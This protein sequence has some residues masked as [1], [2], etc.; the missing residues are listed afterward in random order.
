MNI[1]YI[2]THDAGVYLEPYGRHIP[3][4]NLMKFTGEGT[5]AHNFFN[6]FPTCSPSRSALLTGMMP[7]S[8][9]MSG[10]AHRGWRITNYD[11]HL[12]RYLK[13]QGYYTVLCGMQHEACLMRY[14]TRAAL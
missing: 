4:P 5:L 14:E 1:V 8:N 9:G 13:T 7:H 10:L 3:M 12:A 6:A 11:W 2:H